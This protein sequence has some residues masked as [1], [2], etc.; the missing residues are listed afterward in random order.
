MLNLE[1]E[2]AI[3]NAQTDFSTRRVPT[4]AVQGRLGTVRTQLDVRA[5]ENGS[6]F[7]CHRS[8]WYREGESNLSVSRGYAG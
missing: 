1:I 5:Y 8:T 7:I 4:E 3:A 6:F 2:V